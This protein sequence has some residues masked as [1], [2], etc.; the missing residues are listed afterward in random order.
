MS[1]IVYL[2][3][4]KSNTIY[5]YLNESVWDPEKKKCIC[6]RK[7]IG[8]L[9]PDTGKIVPNRSSKPKQ[10]PWIKSR[11]V[12]K[13]FEEVSK[14]L[15]LSEVLS[16]CFPDDWKKI[17]T[18]AYYVAANNNELQFCHHWCETHKTPDG[19]IMTPEKTNELLKNIDSNAISLFFTLWRLRLQPDE[20][21]VDT[22]IFRESSDDMTN[23][24]KNLGIEP[25]DRQ[26]KTKMEL[27]FTTKNDIPLCYE[28]S[29]LSTGHVYGDYDVRRESFRKL[30]SFLD[31]E[32]GDVFDASLIAYAGS[33]IIV[34]VLPDNEF[35]KE[36]TEKVSKSIANAENGR[37]VFGNFLFIETFMNHYNGKR[38][39]THICYDPNRAANDLSAFL[40]IVNNC[41]YEIE[42]GNPIPDHQHIYDKYLLTREENDCTIAEY[43]SQA[44]MQHSNNAGYSV[45][46]SNF[47]RNPVSALIP[48]LQRKMITDMFNGMMNEYDSNSINLSTEQVY[49]SRIFIQFIALIIK[50]EIERKMNVY[51]LNK[52]LSYKELIE[53]LD[54]IRTVRMPGSKKM[55]DT[56]IDGPTL[57]VMNLLGIGPEED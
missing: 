45:Y 6:K 36:L 18:L 24:A 57:R 5:A 46:I 1:S 29:S 23:Y 17:S 12:T 56:E 37:M 41:R 15:Q 4:S 22:I 55:V 47:T 3:N 48:F 10:T 40:T 25:D 39:Y 53:M 20:V 44:I 33:N 52:T 49:L 31:E 43:N 14:E 51:K 21:Y 30:T 54:S 27:Y 8:H 32:K 9:D 26:Y 50:C 34:R 35:V 7:C 2:R 28:L 16:L 42:S 38:Y 19:K 13:L 11:Y